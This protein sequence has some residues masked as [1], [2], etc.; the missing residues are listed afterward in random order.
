MT[1]GHC[2]GR[3]PRDGTGANHGW[4]DLGRRT[5]REL[6]L[7]TTYGIATGDIGSWWGALQPHH[8]SGAATHYRPGWPPY[9]PEP[10]EAL[11]AEAGPRR[12]EAAAGCGLRARVLTLRL[13]VL[14]EKAIGLDPDP[15]MIAAA[16]QTGAEEA[17]R[18]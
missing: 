8:L 12:D 7:L 2:L 1:F 3:R 4:P 15:D 6:G 13:A 9:S 14:F 10:E 11:A 18:R 5:V 16:R 17:K